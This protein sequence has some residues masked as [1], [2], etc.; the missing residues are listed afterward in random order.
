MTL[1]SKFFSRVHR[2]FFLGLVLLNT[3]PSFATLHFSNNNDPLTVAAAL[4]IS[5][6]NE[7]EIYWDQP[8]T[9]LFAIPILKVYLNSNGSIAATQILRIP[10]NPAA[11]ET[12]DLAI[13]AIKRAEPFYIPSEARPPYEFI[14]T[15]LFRD[16][17]K[18]KLRVL[19]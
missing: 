13:A 14:Q 9:I 4:K 10:S 15:F 3:S 19:D 12:V 11:Q 1:F 8:P 16:D 18:F 6:A 5:K 2:F 17:L 7:P